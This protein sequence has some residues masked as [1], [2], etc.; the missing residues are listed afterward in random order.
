MEW[1]IDFPEVLD[2]KGTFQGFDIVIA[3]PPYGIMNKKQN[4]KEAII[5]PAN[6]NATT[7]FPE[8]LD[9]AEH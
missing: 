2:E 7:M 4:I 5:V 8:L 6:M 1:A 9:K 3:N